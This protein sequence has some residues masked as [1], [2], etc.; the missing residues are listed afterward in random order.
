[1][2][3]QS[4]NQSIDLMFHLLNSAV[5][6]SINHLNQGWL[7]IILAD[8]LEKIFQLENFEMANNIYVE[9]ENIA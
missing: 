5:N 2:A 4:I 8:D 6:Q 7:Y 1:V 3:N 9:K